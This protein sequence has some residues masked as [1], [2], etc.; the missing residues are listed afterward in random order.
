MI[1]FMIA[2]TRVLGVSGEVTVPRDCSFNSLGPV[3][4]STDLQLKY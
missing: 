1:C 3:K 4:V 2:V